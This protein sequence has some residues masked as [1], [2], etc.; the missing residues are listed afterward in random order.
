MGLKI[1]REFIARAVR[2]GEI[3]GPNEFAQ[4]RYFVERYVPGSEKL[5]HDGLHRLSSRIFRALANGE[6]IELNDEVP[7]GAVDLTP[8]A[9]ANDLER[10]INRLVALEPGFGSLAPSEQKARAQTEL[11]QIQNTI[12]E[13]ASDADAE[14]DD[15]T[16]SEH[17]QAMRNLDARD[18]TFR[19]LSHEERCFGPR[20][21]KEVERVRER[22]LNARENERRRLLAEK[23]SNAEYD[24]NN[25]PPVDVERSSTNYDGAP[26]AAGYTPEMAP[27]A[28]RDLPTLGELR[29]FPGARGVQSDLARTITFMIQRQPSFANHTWETQLSMA[30]PVLRSIMAREPNAF[31]AAG[32][33]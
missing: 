31:A 17:A 23:G 10:M 11:E 20:I 19:K 3:E 24:T 32:G 2:R 18:P 30:M 7:A 6:E 25:P 4:V 9:G 22:R 12:D 15:P 27:M 13:A 33:M 16:L 28:T 29:T 21:R 14:N 26:R 8:F 1:D 5:D